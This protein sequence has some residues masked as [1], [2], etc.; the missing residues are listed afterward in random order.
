MK[1]GIWF[2]KMGGIRRECSLPVI[3]DNDVVAVTNQEKAEM[4]AKGFKVNNSK[5][6]TDELSWRVKVMEE[7]KG[8]IEKQATSECAW[9]GFYFIWAGKSIKWSQENF[10][11]LA[12][13]VSIIN[14]K[15]IT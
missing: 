5:N 8:L 13:C 3:K 7:N 15:D 1:F 2:K 11:R 4:V 6:W 12:G 10:T 9:Q 14:I